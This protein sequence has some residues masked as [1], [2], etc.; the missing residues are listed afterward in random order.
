M[1]NILWRLGG[2]DLSKEGSRIR[3]FIDVSLD[4]QPEVL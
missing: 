4:G 1:L 3:V 2:I